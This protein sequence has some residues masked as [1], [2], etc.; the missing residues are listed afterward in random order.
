MSCRSCKETSMKKRMRPREPG[1]GR[2]VQLFTY[3]PF[4]FHVTRALA[5]ADNPTKYQP[6]LCWPNPEWVGPFIDIDEQHIE[7]ADL[8]KPVVF[9]TLITT[10]RP[11]HLLIDGN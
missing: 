10:G 11:W 2:A 6:R 4:E 7:E 1:P 9:A 5:L 3:G 8:G